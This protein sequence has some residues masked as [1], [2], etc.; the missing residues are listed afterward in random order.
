MDDVD[1]FALTAAEYRPPSPRR[2][3]PVL[4]RVPKDF[5]TATDLTSVV[6]ERFV[7]VLERGRFTGWTL[8][9][10]EI[11]RKDGRS[12][13]GYHG[14]AV[15]GR[16]R[17]DNELTRPAIF[18]P[19]IPGLPPRRGWN[20]LFFDPGSWDGSDI[21]LGEGTGFVIVIHAVRLALE[22]ASISNLLM[23]PLSEQE[24]L[25]PTLPDL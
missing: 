21:F 11:V 14:L 9:P 25:S 15:T 5:I 6:S 13:Q 19:L 17:I 8:Y 23:T 12:V 4:G 20:G 18:P 7:D 3:R 1:P 22:A 2:Y 24:N 10:V 16:C